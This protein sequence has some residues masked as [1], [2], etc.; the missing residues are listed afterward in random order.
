[1]ESNSETRERQT[2]RQ[3]DRE[4]ETDRDRQRQTETDRE[5]EMNHCLLEHTGL[6]V[7][8]VKHRVVPEEVVAGRRSQEVGGGG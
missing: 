1:M 2:D 4:T 3:R 8:R 6:L 7:R 5:R